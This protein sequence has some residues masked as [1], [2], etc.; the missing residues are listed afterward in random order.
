MTGRIHS[1]RKSR[2]EEQFLKNLETLVDILA[3]EVIIRHTNDPDKARMISNSLGYFLRDCF[4]IMDRTFVMKLVHKYLIA[5][6]E[7]MRYY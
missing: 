5:F 6:A 2:F 7:S 3:Q 4:S 1:P